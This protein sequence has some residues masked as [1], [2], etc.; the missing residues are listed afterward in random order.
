MEYLLYKVELP[1][2]LVWTATIFCLSIFMFLHYNLQDL[3]LPQN[4][5]ITLFLKTRPN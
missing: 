2:S 4:F 5:C 3:Y 1:Y